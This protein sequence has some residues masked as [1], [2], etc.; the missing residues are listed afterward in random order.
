MTSFLPA[1]RRREHSSLRM[2]RLRLLV[3]CGHVSDCLGRE[4]E[5]ED[6]DRQTRLI[7]SCGEETAGD[8]DEDEEK[9]ETGEE[10]RF[11]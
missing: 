2:A 9:V 5:C 6:Y 4:E 10:L 11:R 7:L 3:G 1:T 8:Q